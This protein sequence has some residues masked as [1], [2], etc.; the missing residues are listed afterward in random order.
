MFYYSL[1]NI[2]I[3]LFVLIV[4]SAAYHDIKNFKLPNIHSLSVA[5]L[6]PAFVLSTDGAV[7]WVG[8]IGVASVVLLIGFGL[9]ALKYCGGGDVKLMA[10]I[11]L[12]AGP[13]LGLEF[14]IIT[15]LAGGVI[16]VAYLLYQQATILV[17]FLPQSRQQNP[18]SLSKKPM[19]YGIAIASGA[20]YVAFTLL[21]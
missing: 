14:V 1:S 12:W 10:A 5:L 6:Y 18:T 13:G 2:T 20:V 16:A 15:A 11:A 17:P 3:C 4:A 21:R 9:F 19:P 8:A 7:D